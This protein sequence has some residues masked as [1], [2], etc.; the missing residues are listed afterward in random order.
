[1]CVYLRYTFVV[2]PIVSVETQ[3]MCMHVYHAVV[4]VPGDPFYR[5]NLTGWRPL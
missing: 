1:M 3:I 2:V 5:G 4:L